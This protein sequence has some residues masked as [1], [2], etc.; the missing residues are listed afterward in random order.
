[1]IWVSAGRPVPGAKA[2]GLTMK[3]PLK[4]LGTLGPVGGRIGSAC[5]SPS[6]PLQWAYQ[7]ISPMALAPGTDHGTGSFH[8]PPRIRSAAARASGRGRET[9][10]P[11]CRI[12]SSNSIT[13]GQLARWQDRSPCRCWPHTGVTRGF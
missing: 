2:T 6:Q 13:P 11:V 3:S 1:M 9:A 10:R 8:H 7:A 4:G 5:V 12:N